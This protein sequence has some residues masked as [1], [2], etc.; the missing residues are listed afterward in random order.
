MRAKQISTAKDLEVYQ[1]AYELAMH[2]TL[3]SYPE[4]SPA[5]ADQQPHLAECLQAEARG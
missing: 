3:L 1:V 4:A 5:G 2:I